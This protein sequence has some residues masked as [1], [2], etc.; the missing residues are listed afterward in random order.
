MV[1]AYLLWLATFG[2]LVLL[3]DTNTKHSL[4]RNSRVAWW[5]QQTGRLQMHKLIKLYIFPR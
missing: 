5:L 4:E 3:N 1:L 2:L